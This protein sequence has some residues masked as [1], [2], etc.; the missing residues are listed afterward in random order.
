MA[1]NWY[2]IAFTPDDVLAAKD[3]EMK[4]HFER[5]FQAAGSPEDAALFKEPEPDNPVYYFSP[6]GAR[7]AMKLISHHSATPSEAP[8]LSRVVF[9]AGHRPIEP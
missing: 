5:F 8:S 1:N 4:G 2:R 7:I 6:G 9:L 3:L